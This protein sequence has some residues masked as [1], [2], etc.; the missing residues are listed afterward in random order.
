MLSVGR[1][2]RGAGYVAARQFSSD[3]AVGCARSPWRAA[4]G[5]TVRVHPAMVEGRSISKELV[6]GL[7]ALLG[8]VSGSSGDCGGILNASRPTIRLQTIR[9]AGAISGD[10]QG[11][12]SLKQLASGVG[13]ET[14]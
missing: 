14:E 7:H 4:Y 9:S 2:E 13:V 5:W 12:S 1:A 6:G 3:L 8:D 11:T 10:A